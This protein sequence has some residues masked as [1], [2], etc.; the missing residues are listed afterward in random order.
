MC[1][2]N[3]IS[4]KHHTLVDMNGKRIITRDHRGWHSTSDISD[5]PYIKSVNCVLLL[6]TVSTHFWEGSLGIQLREYTR[7]ESVGSLMCQFRFNNWYCLPSNLLVSVEHQVDM[8]EFQIA[9]CG[10]GTCWGILHGFAYWQ[11]HDTQYCT[12]IQLRHVSVP[13]QLSDYS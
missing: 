11:C 9:V 13:G 10:D 7:V 3:V 1:D 2:C 12:P 4:L 8:T 6:L 5:L